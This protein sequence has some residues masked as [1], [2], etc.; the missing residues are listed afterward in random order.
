MTCALLVA[1]LLSQRLPL[2]ATPPMGWNSYDCFSYAVD[3]QQVK[4]NA[5]YM[6]RRLKRF[7]WEYIVVDYIW[8]A[9]KLKPGFAPDQSATFQPSLAMDAFGRLQPDPARF[10]SSATRT[11]FKSL[12]DYCHN[13]GLKFGIHLMR[14]IPRQAVALKTPVL[15]T[16]WT[17]EDAANRASKCPWLNHMY[18]LDM[19]KPAG[20]AYLNSLFK[21]YAEWGVDFVK[22][23]DLSQPYSKA[24]VEGYRAA[25][26]HCGRPIVLSLSPGPT[27]IA[28]GRNVSLFANMWRLV[29]DLWDDWPELNR[30]MDVVAEWSAFRKP[31]HWPDIDM[32]PLGKLREYGPNT[33]PPNTQSRFTPDEA[34]TLMTLMCINQNPLM[35]GG[36]LPETDAA[37]LRLITNPAAIAVDQ[38]GVGGHLDSEVGGVGQWQAGAGKDGIYVAFINRNDAPAAVTM[39]RARHIH[40][41]WTHHELKSG[42]TIKL[43]AHGSVLLRV[44]I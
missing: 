12:A 17:A 2:A 14:G 28:D 30:A 32:L 24:E 38:T 43:P 42:Q 5:D 1:A 40:E 41:L 44:E 31:G 20:Q 21:L 4:A 33:G 8:S 22:V 15:G 18:G 11:G 9:P 26:Q 6:A 35:F 10:P 34:R 19:S 25:I 16:G 29:G 37:T 7:G 23:D 3:E 27:P 13:K 39:P 36:N